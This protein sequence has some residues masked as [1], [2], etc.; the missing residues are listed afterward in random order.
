MFS[1]IYK[2]SGTGALGW[3]HFAG[4]WEDGMDEIILTEGPMKADMSFLITR[5]PT[6]A[7]PGVNTIAE[8]MK[9]LDKLK[10]RGLKKVRIALDMDYT[11]KK[12][13]I[14]DGVEEEK[15]SQVYLAYRKLIENIVEHGLVY[16]R[17]VWPRQYK[18]ID[19]FLAAMYRGVK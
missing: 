13:E 10:K 4:V 11:D 5:I 15:E 8:A 7:I 17:M 1:S 2:E 9:M 6:I 16:T 3:A 12:I 19:D 14:V 18:G